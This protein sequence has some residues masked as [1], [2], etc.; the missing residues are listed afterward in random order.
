M[1][2]LTGVIPL[3]KPRGMTSHDCVNKLRKLLHTKKVGHTGTLDPEVDGVLPMCIGRA[4]KIAEYLSDEGKAYKGVIRL[5][6][7]TTTEDAIGDIVEEKPVQQSWTRA[8]IEAVF[9]RFTGDIEQV[10]PLY[11]AVK[12]NGKK[13]Y[14]YA[15]AGIPVERPI[16]KVTIHKLELPP[17]EDCY[18][19]RIPFIVDCSKGTYIRTLTVDIGKALGFPAHM[20]SLT[21][22]RSGQFELKDCVDFDD[23][24]TAV[25][26]KKTEDIL[27]GIGQALRS[28]PSWVVDEKTEQD[29]LNGKVMPLPKHFQNE[30][31]AVYNKH[32]DCLAIY[33]KH[34]EKPDMIKPEK[35]LVIK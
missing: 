31:L 1:D 10:T 33:Q 20:E 25:K 32:G 28:F 24:E 16:R 3:Y 6:F 2:G 5:G 13:L 23:I 35:V 8:E 7:S 11:S 14:E 19:E 9:R 21:R 34:P 27:V 30:H 22:I 18:T 15:R 4:T 17:E 29:V 12:V 26:T